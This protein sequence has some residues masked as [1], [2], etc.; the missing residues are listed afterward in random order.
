ML[1]IAGLSQKKHCSFFEVSFGNCF[2]HKM[3]Y[4]ASCSEALMP[5]KVWNSTDGVK[6]FR[7]FGYLVYNG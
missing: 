2:P 5:K 7:G 4:G 6:S 3:S 1:I